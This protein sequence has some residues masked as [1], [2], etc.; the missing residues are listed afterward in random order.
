M[1]GSREAILSS[2]GR[3]NHNRNYAIANLS[4]SKGVSSMQRQGES[5]MREGLTLG[6]GF[7]RRVKVD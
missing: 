4:E 3:V 7:D 5:D 2:A 6:E 1:E